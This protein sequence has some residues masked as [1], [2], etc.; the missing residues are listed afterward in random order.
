MINL[1][2]G[3]C[4]TRLVLKMLIN[5]RPFARRRHFTATTRILFDF[6]FKSKFRNHSD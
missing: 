4:K 5:N 3:T 6:P 2:R 1:K